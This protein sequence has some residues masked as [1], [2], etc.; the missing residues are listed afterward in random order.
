L[1]PVAYTEHQT[2][3][4]HEADE[5]IYE[6]PTIHPRMTDAVCASLSGSKVISV[7]ES[8]RKHDQAIVSRVRFTSGDLIIVHNPTGSP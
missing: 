8:A 1:E 3:C 2:A 4:F 6:T 7:E 5:T